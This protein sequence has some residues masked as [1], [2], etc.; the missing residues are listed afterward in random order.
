M[1]ENIQIAYAE[2]FARDLEKNRSEQE[3]IARQLTELQA[4]LDGL[5]TDEKWL[6]EML[7]TVPPTMVAQPAATE[8]TPEPAPMEPHLTNPSPAEPDVAVPQPRQAKTTSKPAR[9]TAPKKP[10]AKKA[11]TKKATLKQAAATT[12]ASAAKK[13]AG[14]PLRELIETILSKHAG[15]PRLVNEIRT[16]LVEMHPERTT[17]IQVVRNNLESLTRKGIVEKGTQQGAVM[18]SKPAPAGI[19][20]E[21]NT[22]APAEA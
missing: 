22:K 3:D 21:E 5:K 11:V 7:G 17:S 4:R 1:A 6:T 20:D 12:Q 8:A 10:A 16:E 9:K 15:E 2:R 19:P 14:P 13:T 18:Y